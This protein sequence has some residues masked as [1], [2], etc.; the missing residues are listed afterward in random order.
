MKHFDLDDIDSL[1]AYNELK[2]SYE[3][4]IGSLINE[5]ITILEINFSLKC[6]ISFLLG[7][8]TGVGFII[9]RWILGLFIKTAIPSMIP[10]F[11]ITWILLIYDHITYF[12][13]F[14]NIYNKEKKN[15]K[16]NPK[17]S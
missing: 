11:L 12:N 13:E 15:K 3:D 17:N 1:A 5:N 8:Q 6:M 9:I 14:L 7:I 16:S 2:S 10:L 4:L